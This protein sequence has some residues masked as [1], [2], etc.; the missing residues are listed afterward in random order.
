MGNKLKEELEQK[1]GGMSGSMSL[2]DFGKCKRCES[3][4]L[5]C[6]C[7]G[8]PSLDIIGVTVDLSDVTIKDRLILDIMGEMMQSIKVS[9]DGSLVI[10]YK[11]WHSNKKLMGLIKEHNEKHGTNF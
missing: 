5:N 1:N 3:P 9:E 11:K 10:G 2:D 8:G 7:V 6:F 4:V